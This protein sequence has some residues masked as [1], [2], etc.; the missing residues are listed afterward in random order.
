MG[1]SSNLL[2]HG[3]ARVTTA[4]GTSPRRVYILN[5]PNDPGNGVRPMTDLLDLIERA[6]ERL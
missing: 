4:A 6:K 5:A 3:I 1:L 2:V